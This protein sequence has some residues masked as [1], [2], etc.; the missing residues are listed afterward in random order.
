MFAKEKLFINVVKQNNNLKIEHKKYIKNK[1][2]SGDS[3]TFLVEGDILPENIAQK[4]NNLQ[5]EEDFS[6]ISTLLLSDTTKLIPKN[7]SSKVKDCEIVSF[8]SEYD[9]AVLK[10][11]LFETQNYFGKTG[12]DY[13]Y[14]AFHII[15]SF[16]SKNNPKS[17]LLFFIYNSRAYIVIVDKSSQIIYN[18]VVDLLSFDAVKRTHFYE[19]DLEGQKLYDELYSLELSEILQKILKDFYKKR[20]DIFV[21][22]ISMIFS[23]KNLTKEQIS[24]LSLELT[25]KIDEFTVDI[26]EELFELSKE[27]DG[28]NSFISPRKKKKRRDPRY[29]FLI[30][31]FAILFFGAYKI[32]EQI[33]FKNLAMKL[34]LIE[35]KKEIVFEKLPD[36]NLENSKIELRIKSIFEAVPD[37]I[38]VK[39]LK[40]TKDNLELKVNS[41][42]DS[43]LN[44]L[45]LSLN[46][47]YLNNSVKKLD[48]TKKE[49]FEAIVV[50]RN[51]LV[52]QNATYLIFSKDYLIDEKFSE[53]DIKEQLKILLPQ[54]SILEFVEKIDAKRVEILS[55]RSNIL[56]KEP[57]EFFD[58]ITRVNNELYS[59]NINYPIV[60]KSTEL[61]IEI[62]F[63][64]DF[65]QLK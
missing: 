6:Y 49:N 19:N 43:S 39:E 34:N 41:K 26:N 45:Q 62:D 16:I 20:S 59:I 33:D 11:T 51:E 28:Q 40:I 32:Y 24:A 60:M 9:I 58:L 55:F 3:S 18:E 65:N 7:L 48:E 53:I 4:L 64:L 31:L 36:H 14:S 27:K 52:L 1:E 38:Q 63:V 35:S 13:I 30:I 15:K 46:T 2:H 50:S 12:V 17:E 21:Q 44:L 56:V 37:L 5:K 47:L 23:L 22:K 61:G 29:L 54:D 42:D 57:K 10:T 25:L 8:D